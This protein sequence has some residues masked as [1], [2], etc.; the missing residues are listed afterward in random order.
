MDDVARLA[1]GVAAVAAFAA[2]PLSGWLYDGEGW[3]PLEWWVVVSA[4]S[5]V[6]G[7]AASV[8]RRRAP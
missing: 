1:L 8:R 4:L 3:P 2:G 7:T 6:V 5:L